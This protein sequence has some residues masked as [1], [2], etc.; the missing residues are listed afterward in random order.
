MAGSSAD[1]GNVPG[2]LK[3]NFGFTTANRSSYSVSS[4]IN[5]QNDLKYS[6]PVLLEGCNNQTNVFL[7]IWYS[8]EDCHEWVCDGYRQSTQTGC[9]NGAPISV[10]TLFFHMNWGWH[11]IYA[12]TDFSG[13]FAFDNWT[14]TGAGPNGSNG[15]FSICARHGNGDSSIKTTE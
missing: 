2:A 1:G 11:E 12:S 5:I 7:G 13:W 10:T 3:A 4:W 9:S 8:Y 15:K 14:I 6:Q